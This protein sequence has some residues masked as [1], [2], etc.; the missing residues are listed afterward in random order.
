MIENTAVMSGAYLV[1]KAQD[2]GDKFAKA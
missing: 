2:T 1:V